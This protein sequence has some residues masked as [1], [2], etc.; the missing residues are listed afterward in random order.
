MRFC[1]WQAL[2]YTHLIISDQLHKFGF[3]TEVA[4]F[5]DEKLSYFIIFVECIVLAAQY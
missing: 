1:K 2:L 3:R 4:R 5:L